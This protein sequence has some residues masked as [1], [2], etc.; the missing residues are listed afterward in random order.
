MYAIAQPVL[1]IHAAELRHGVPTELLG[2][3]GALLRIALPSVDVMNQIKLHLMM[4]SWSAAVIARSISR[5]GYRFRSF[6]QEAEVPAPENP[7][8]R[9]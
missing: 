1:M 2:L 6:P 8:R 7:S 9:I 5:T 3:F 4:W